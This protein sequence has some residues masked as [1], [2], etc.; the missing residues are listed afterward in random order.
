[1]DS[2]NESMNDALINQPENS[3]DFRSGFVAITGRPNA[4]KSTLINQLASMDLA[5]TSPKPQTTRTTIRA[6]INKPNGQ[7][8]L[9]DT[10]GLLRPQDKLGKVM[11]DAIARTV[12]DADIVLLLVDAEAEQRRRGRSA[13]EMELLSRLKDKEKD[14]ILVLNKV[15]LIAKELLLPLI[16]RWSERYPFA[17]IIPVSARNGDGVQLL[18]NELLTRLPV[19]PRYFPEDSITDQTERSLTA[20]LIREQIL[21]HTHQE[22][23]HGT[24]VIINSFEEEYVEPSRTFIHIDASILTEKDTHKGILIGKGGSMLKAIGTDARL[25]IEKM[26]GCKVYLELHVKV[27]EDWQNRSGILRDIGYLQDS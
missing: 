8:I 25:Q 20:E 14:I 2:I 11:A 15:D 1:M 26:V 3:G 9:V 13:P 23:P 16:A 12:D 6:V 27:R 10:P 18:E 19:G 5:I 24:A 17:A 4:G 22:I 7:I 21:R